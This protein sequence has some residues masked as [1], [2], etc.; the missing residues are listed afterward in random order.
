MLH[1]SLLGRLD[2]GKSDSV[3]P[4]RNDHKTNLT[5]PPAI[6]V[7]GHVMR[8][9]FMICQGWQGSQIPSS[10]WLSE[11]ETKFPGSERTDSRT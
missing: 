11:E 9:M 6:D 2:I 3:C 5:P 4:S 8:F 10:E 1:L 7:H